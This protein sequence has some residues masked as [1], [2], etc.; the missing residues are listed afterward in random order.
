MCF[1]GKSSDESPKTMCLHR[2]S[3]TRYKESQKDLKRAWEP[4]QAGRKPQCHQKR[5][6][7][8]LQLNWWRSGQYST[9]HPSW[10]LIMTDQWNGAGQTAKV[11]DKN[12]Y[13]HDTMTWHC[14]YWAAWKKQGNGKK[15]S[16]GVLTKWLNAKDEAGV[17]EIQWKFSAL[18]LWISQPGASWGTEA[19]C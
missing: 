12:H 1:V 8:S 18:A 11:S 17:R 5:L 7:K 9:E 6:V 2:S 14:P 19:S 16:R 10:L 4:Q 15:N 13:H 3:M